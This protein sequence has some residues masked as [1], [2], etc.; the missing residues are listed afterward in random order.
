ML[1]EYAV[2]PEG[3]WFSIP[4]GEDGMEKLNVF[5]FYTLGAKVMKH[6]WAFASLKEP[7]EYRVLA[8]YELKTWFQSFLDLSVDTNWKATRDR[9][10][11]LLTLI[12]QRAS[13]MPTEVYVAPFDTGY[14]YNILQLIKVF[15]TTF[16]MESQ[17]ANVF[18]V[19][20]KGTH[21]TLDLMERAFD[22]LPLDTRNRL[23]D[24][25]KADIREAGRC[26]A[27]DCHTACGYHILRA[28][29]RLIAKYVDKVAK[30]VVLKKE[31]RDWGAY[32]TVLTNHGG[33]AKVIGTLDHIRVHYRNPIIH[34]QDT[35]GPDDAFS[36]FNTSI[37][38]MIQLDAAIEA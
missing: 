10:T 4:V 6:Y 16:A 12:E 26:L 25:T 2:M 31:P 34:P 37:S 14:E 13:D 17:D 30:N 21:S 3:L 38:A 33:D 20:Q 36:L 32:I 8:L 22:N 23:S 1:A 9:A 28:T 29:E 5:S 11:Q 35:L 18:L 24:A 15:E 19:S 7:M 27:L